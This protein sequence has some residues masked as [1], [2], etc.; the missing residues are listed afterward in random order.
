[1]TGSVRAAS[2]VHILAGAES[3]RHV[4]SPILWLGTCATIGVAAGPYADGQLPL[5]N[6]WVTEDYETVFSAWMWLFLATFVTAVLTVGRHA[7]PHAAEVFAGQP[8]DAGQRMTAVLLAGAVPAG[9]SALAAGATCAVIARAGGIAVGEFTTTQRLVPTAA[10]A[11]VAVAVV[12][13]GYALG[14]AT[15]ATI[16]SRLAAVVL[17]TMIAMLGIGWFWIWRYPVS[18]LGLY[19]APLS[20]TDLGP[21]PSEEVKARWRILHGPADAEHMPHWYGYVRDTDMI[22]WH[23]VYLFGI[24]LLLSAYCVRRAG[25]RRAGRVAVAGLLVTA[26]GAVMQVITYGGGN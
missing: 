8:T 24:V 6:P 7:D 3:L 15:A 5:S 21:N 26:F 20:H 18:V 13:V 11:A 23:A 4:R 22:A 12:A 10:E 16:T 2:P 19:A 14:V 17:G 25:G 9:L 1:M